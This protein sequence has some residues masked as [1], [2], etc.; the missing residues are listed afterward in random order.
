MTVYVRCLSAGLVLLGGA[1]HPV[2]ALGSDSFQFNGFISQGLLWTSDN[3]LF[4]DSKAGSLDFGELALNASY[5]VTPRLR[6]AGQV[7]SRRAGATDDGQLHL[8]Y[9]LLD[10]AVHS[11]MTR[12]AGLRLGRVKNPFGFYN[13]TRDVPFTRPSILLPQGLYLDRLR[14]V[15]L[16]A[17]GGQLYLE[18]DTA[19][20]ILTAQLNL[21]VATCVDGNLETVLLNQDWP[22]KFATGAPLFAGRLLYQT[23]DGRWQFAL[24]G[25]RLDLD[26]E[27]GAA[28]DPLG[29]GR[30]D[31][32]SGILSLGFE[33]LPWRVTAEYQALAVHFYGPGAGFGDA[34][35][36]GDNYALQLDYRMA[37]D[38]EVFLRH[39]VNILDRNDPDGRS[40]AAH[41][42]GVP[43]SSR[44]GRDWTLGLRHDL[45][46]HWMVRAEYHWVQ[47]TSWLPVQENPLTEARVPHWQLLALLLSYRF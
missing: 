13:D 30:I 39:D 40:Y 22:G 24:S 6:A 18:A 2:G 11:T 14:N 9:G 20:G 43:A 31:I 12:R 38:W 17:D 4:G 44:Y 47:G 46:A 45:N 42:P 5:E 34:T 25:Y 35:F 15:A 21:G 27:P 28:A 16:A 29:E 41:N 36:V 32:S 37:P 3:Q 26:Y 7:L 10:Y 8:D 1:S 33:S 23:P 19:Q